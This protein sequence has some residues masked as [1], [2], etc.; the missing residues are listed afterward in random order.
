MN[1]FNAH[2]LAD[3]ASTGG[4]VVGTGISAALLLFFQQS[5]ER[6]LPYLII[7]AVVILIDLVFGIRAAKRK[8]DRIRISRAIRR[9]IG[10]AVEYFCW[11][12]L[13]SS[14]AVATGYTI[15]ETGL[16]LV[17]IG[18]ELISIAQNWYLWK[19]GHKAGVKV[20]AAKVIES[21]V[22]AKTGANIEGAITIKK[23]E[24]SENKEVVKID[25]KED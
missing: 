5:F 2:I 13:A 1:D 18:V 24:E 10:K 6:M 4:V 15:I 14:L 8:G 25:G 11:V 9:T 17:V 12:V 20:D 16:M 19:F 23:A 3:E 21:V 22:E 7:A